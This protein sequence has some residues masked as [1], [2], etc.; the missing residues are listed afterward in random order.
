[1]S[2]SLKVP[3]PHGKSALLKKTSGGPDRT[4]DWFRGGHLLAS[5][6]LFAFATSPPASRLPTRKRGRPPGR[7]HLGMSAQVAGP[8]LSLAGRS[9][10]LT[11]DSVTDLPARPQ[12]RSCHN[13]RA[14][15]NNGRN[16]AP[17]K[18][19]TPSRPASSAPPARIPSGIPRTRAG[20]P[21]RPPGSGSPCP[22]SRSRCPRPT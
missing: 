11:G 12:A 17:A 21:A 8:A 2:S 4:L 18:P 20:G 15:A 16:A 5:A 1:M 19:V 13:A 22:A 10:C 6:Y 14:A 9:G 3:L 7:R